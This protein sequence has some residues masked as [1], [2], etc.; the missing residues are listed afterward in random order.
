[1]IGV[2]VDAD[3]RDPLRLY[4]LTTRKELRDMLR[5]WLRNTQRLWYLVWLSGPTGTAD[6]HITLTL[7]PGHAQHRF[8]SR[9]SNRQCWS[10]CQV[11][12]SE[13]P[14]RVIPELWA[15]LLRISD[16]ALLS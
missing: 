1:M 16:C 10:V 12:L 2:E 8:L 3:K 5:K 7:D 4:D 13:I 11:R 6:C 14:R 15:M 9:H